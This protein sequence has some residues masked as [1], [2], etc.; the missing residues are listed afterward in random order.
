VV[1]APFDGVIT[2]RNERTLRRDWPTLHL[3]RPAP[4]YKLPIVLSREEVRRVLAGVRKPIYR[5]CLTTIDSCGLRLMEGAQ[6]RVAPPFAGHD[7]ALRQSGYNPTHQMGP[8][9]AFREENIRA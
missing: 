6:L 9:L 7:C 3:A 4:E 1:K 5:V 8:L 2:L